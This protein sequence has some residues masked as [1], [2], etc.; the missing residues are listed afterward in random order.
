MA[1]NA[2]V[3]HHFSSYFEILGLQ[4]EVQ[5]FWNKGVTLEQAVIY[6]EN[7]KLF[8]ND[9][10]HDLVA[11][12]CIS[13]VGSI[14]VGS[15]LMKVSDAAFWF[16]MLKKNLN[17]P[18]AHLSTLG[19]SF[20][21]KNQETLDSASFL[22][23]TD[24]SHL[25]KLSVVA[26]M[27]LLQLEKKFGV[28]SASTSEL[29]SLQERGLDALSSC[30]KRGPHVV[31]KLQRYIEDLHPRV[32]SQL[33]QRSMGIIWDCNKKLQLMT[34]TCF[35]T[36]IEVSCAGATSANGMYVPTSEFR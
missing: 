1:E 33:L 7:A 12:Q 3:L 35:P 29:S 34:A 26:A 27:E 30:T 23:L 17:K 9:Q 2:V 18:K 4:N 10:M 13:L 5:A 25:P 32:L 16:A 6:L 8:H 11:E 36:E 28:T 14:V 15:R 24:E 19:S 21:S 22:K 31:T 20:C